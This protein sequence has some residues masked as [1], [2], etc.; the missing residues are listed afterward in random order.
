M[1]NSVKFW[2][3]LVDSTMTSHLLFANHVTMVASFETFLISPGFLL[4]F[5]ESHQISKS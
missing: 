1:A 4:N 5:K 3:I 2:A